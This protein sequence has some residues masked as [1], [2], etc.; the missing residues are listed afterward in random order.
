MPIVF[1]SSQNCWVDRYSIDVE[2]GVGRLV[3]ESIY[4]CDIFTVFASWQNPRNLQK[5]TRG[6]RLICRYMKVNSYKNHR[7]IC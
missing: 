7:R 3:L 1:Y 5:D 6:H 4:H 2:V